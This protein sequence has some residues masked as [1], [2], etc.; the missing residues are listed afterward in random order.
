MPRRVIDKIRE[1]I[2]QNA[3]D[4]TM[5]AN[6]EMAEDNLTIDEVE[7][8]ILNGKIV[9]TEK[10]DQRGPRYTIHGISLDQETAVGVVGRFT[11]TQRFLIVTVYEIREKE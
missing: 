1:I 8:S 7:H 10:D 9:K 3:Y 11:E 6:E 2:R 5:H 4:L